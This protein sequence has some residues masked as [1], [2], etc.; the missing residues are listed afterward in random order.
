MDFKQFLLTLDY[1]VPIAALSVL[2]MAIAI[3]SS[4]LGIIELCRVKFRRSAYCLGGAVAPGLAFISLL[5]LFLGTVLKYE[6][7]SIFVILIII[8]VAG[9]LRYHR[10]FMGAFTSSFKYNL[11]S[12]IFIIAAIYYSWRDFRRH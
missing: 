5:S 12:T 2:L 8:A 11:W 3:I 7:T 1:G 4:G 6:S 9:A 10:I